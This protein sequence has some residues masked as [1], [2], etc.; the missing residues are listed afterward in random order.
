MSSKVMTMKE[1]ISTFVKEG[2][3][4]FVAGAQHGEPT[5]AVHE[6]ARQKIKHLTFIGVLT[7]A[8]GVMLYDGLVDRIITGYFHQTIY[9][10]AHAREVLDHTPVIEES[11]HFAIN[12][13]LMA[14]Q[15][16]VPF[17]PAR[18]LLGSDMMVYNSDN[19]K[20]VQ[21]P[22]TGQTL[23]AI[24]AVQPDVAIIHCQRA[25][26]E[27]NAQ[28][29]GSLGVDAEGVG[30]S[31]KVIV[32]A[33]EIVDP[34]VIRRHPNATIVPGFRASAVVHQPWG[35]YPMHL[36]GFYNN[37]FRTFMERTRDR[38]AFDAYMRD[39]VHGVADWDEYLEKTKQAK[40]ADYFENMRIKNPLYSDPIVTGY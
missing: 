13:M 7:Q 1:A 38:E 3:T 5:A 18:N 34:D 14:G 39:L 2:D 22:F 19:L 33:E 9:P 17:L 15:M 40:G 37:D 23:A 35:A 8:H 4:L 32:T 29:W 27:G 24:K 21:C 26:A 31:R 28:K 11:S 12:V 10:I 6:I 30:A 16:N 20:T 25:D 36:A